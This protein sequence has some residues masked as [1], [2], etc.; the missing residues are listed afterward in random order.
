VAAV[1]SLT[2]GRWRSRSGG[3]ARVVSSTYL[4]ATRREV[5]ARRGSARQLLV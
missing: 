1:R 5:L 3:R 4:R 2:V